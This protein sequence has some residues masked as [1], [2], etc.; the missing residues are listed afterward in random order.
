M[1][2]NLWVQ[3]LNQATLEKPGPHLPMVLTHSHVAV[4]S[5]ASESRQL[6][7]PELAEPPA[8]AGARAGA[9]RRV[10]R[11]ASRGAARLTR[12]TPCEFVSSPRWRRVC[13]GWWGRVA[14][15]LN[16]LCGVQVPVSCDLHAPA[17]TLPWNPPEVP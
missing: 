13:C 1:A 10:S 3:H 15:D 16:G 6:A 11:L 7:G 8:A 2:V 14:C 5:A 17:S 12:G 9:P 4:G